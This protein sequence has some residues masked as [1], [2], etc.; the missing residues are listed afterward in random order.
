MRV[1]H[2]IDTSDVGGGQTALLH[3]L[4]GFRGSGVTTALACRGGGPLVDRARSLGT[5]VH[6]IAFDK[7]YLPDKAWALARVVR[8]EGIDLVHSHGLLAT[9]YAALACR[10]FGRRVPLVYHQHGFHHH[11]HSAATR[12]ARIAA[13]RYLARTADRVIA[14]S[15]SDYRQL[16]DE[17]YVEDASVRL[18]HYGLPRTAIPA[19]SA[20]AVSDA[21][22]APGGTPVIGLVARLHAQKGVDTFLRAA[23]LVRQHVRRAIYVVVGVGELEQELRTLAAS[24]DLGRDLRWLS[25]ATPGVAAMPHFTVGVLS[26]RWEGLPLVLLEYMAAA[27]PIVATSV[28]GCLDAVGPQEAEIVPPDDP[29]AM[30]GAILRLL[31]DRDLAAARASAAL[32]RYEQAFTLGAMVRNVRALYDEVYA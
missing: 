6:P 28:P 9:Y 18:V 11:N 13:E 4:D 23:T 29:Q 17:D 31:A 7:R 1:L 3:L 26:S 19:E 20:A 22:A 5:C 8:R 21:I 25:G 30:S 16:L 24:L 27:R 32:A 14:V 12:R 15:S 2:V 10:V